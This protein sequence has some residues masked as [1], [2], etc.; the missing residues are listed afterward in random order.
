M[1]RFSSL[2][3]TTVPRC[4]QK[5]QNHKTQYTPKLVLTDRTTY[6]LWGIGPENA[7]LY[8]SASLSFQCLQHP[9]Q[10]SFYT[11]VHKTYTECMKVKKCEKYK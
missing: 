1:V 8:I 7:D 9:L 3:Q 6:L 5:K 11:I 2:K 4:V 10:K